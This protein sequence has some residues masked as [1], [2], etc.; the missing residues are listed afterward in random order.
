MKS[1]LQSYGIC[2]YIFGFLTVRS[3][4]KKYFC[5]IKHCKK[6]KNVRRKKLKFYLGRKYTRL[7]TNVF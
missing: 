7:S 6:I 5:D 3:Y 4:P 1:L 2:F